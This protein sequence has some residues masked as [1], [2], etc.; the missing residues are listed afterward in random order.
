MRT[1]VNP[2]YG[3]FGRTTEEE[4]S[5]LT[6]MD[7]S[8]RRKK[9][10]LITIVVFGLPDSLFSPAGT[11]IPSIKSGF[12]QRNL[13]TDRFQCH[14]SYSEHPP[15]TQEHLARFLLSFIPPAV[16]ED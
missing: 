11:Q 7:S 4:L 16:S 10:Y 8:G 5:E 6:F 1:I 2:W 15:V 9:N 12:P 14:T 3:I 13:D